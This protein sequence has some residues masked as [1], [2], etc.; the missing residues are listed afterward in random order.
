MSKLAFVF[1]G[2]GAQYVGMGQDF[3]NNFIESKETFDKATEI[4][5]FDVAKLCF[6]E[7]DDINITEYT[8]VAL[9]VTSVAMLK[10]VFSKGYKPDVVAGL[11]L[12]EYSGLVANG[13][14][15]FEDAVKIVRKRGILMQ[16]AVPVGQGGMSAI[17]NFDRDKI[18]KIC[19]EIDGIV[20]IANYNTPNQVVISGEIN[21]VKKASE[22][23]KEVGAKRVILLN[24]SGPFHSMLLKEAGEKL[25]QELLNVNINN[26]NIPY[27][28][29]TTAEY[30]FTNENI[31]ELLQRQVY[32]SV[33]WQ[34]SV[35]KMIENGID[36]F[37]EI[38]AGKTLTAMIKK[39]NKNVKTINIKKVEDL[40]RLG[41]I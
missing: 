2:Q 24:V 8:Q 4:L 5:G 9:L 11:S 26:P 7:N 18:E 28:A 10:V 12:G 17:L 15:N 25:G 30:I 22:L 1:P 29:N 38:G 36:T 16:E 31:K 35:E 34:Q 32:T 3:Y 39:I 6:E 19:S 21:A 33:K 41:E 37:V 40:E 14:L 13:V 20:G 23:I 27:V